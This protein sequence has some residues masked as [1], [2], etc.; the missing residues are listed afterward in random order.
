MENNISN[1][2]I[3]HKCYINNDISNNINSNCLHCKHYHKTGKRLCINCRD[4]GAGEKNLCVDCAFQHE[5]K[6]GLGGNNYEH[7]MVKPSHWL[8]YFIDSRA[9]DDDN[10]NYVNKVKRTSKKLLYFIKKDKYNT[11]DDY[12]YFILERFTRYIVTNN[13]KL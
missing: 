5:F 8:N 6:Y 1:I 4:F 7:N 2:P 3:Y 12:E 10:E 9:F 13:I 11:N